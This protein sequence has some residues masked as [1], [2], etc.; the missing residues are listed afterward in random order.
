MCF[1]LVPSP[2][3]SPMP[4]NAASQELRCRLFSLYLRPWVLDEAHS[5]TEVPHLKDLQKVPPADMTIGPQVCRPLKRIR[6]KQPA[7]PER[8]LVSSYNEA[9]KHYIRGNVVSQHACRHSEGY[10]KS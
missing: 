9:W 10:H 7:P 5:S 6:G 2:E 4:A 1:P 8:L 3:N